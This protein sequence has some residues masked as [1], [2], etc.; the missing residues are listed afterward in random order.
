MISDLS[1]LAIH[2]VNGVSSLFKISLPITGYSASQHSESP[3]DSMY[4][5]WQ[6]LVAVLC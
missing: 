1:S 4:D 3:E 6:R 5:P 2:R